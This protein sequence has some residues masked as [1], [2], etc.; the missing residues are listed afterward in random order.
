MVEPD[1]MCLIEK[2]NKWNKE[3][4]TMGIE[5]GDQMKTYVPAARFC[6]SVKNIFPGI[7]ISIVKIGQSRPCYLYDN[8]N[9]YTGIHILVGQHLYV[10]MIPMYLQTFGENQLKNRI[11]FCQPR[12]W[13]CH[14]LPPGLLHVGQVTK[15]W[16]SCYLVL[17]SID[18]KTR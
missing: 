16:L 13:Y 17:L 3:W 12:V 9:S 8:G 6:F 2:W 14:C 11:E 15:L 5:D 1:N 10:E 18:S 7:G 4:E